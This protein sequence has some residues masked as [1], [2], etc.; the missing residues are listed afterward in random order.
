MLLQNKVHFYFLT[1]LLG[2]RFL[3]VIASFKKLAN[4][5]IYSY[6]RSSYSTVWSQ[7]SFLFMVV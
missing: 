1:P 6:W 5:R 4:P 7:S 2:N 3:S